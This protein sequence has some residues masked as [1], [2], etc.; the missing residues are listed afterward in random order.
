MD[1]GMLS[2]TRLDV[3]NYEQHFLFMRKLE[4]YSASFWTVS[5]L[6]CPVPMEIGVGYPHPSFQGRLVQA[7]MTK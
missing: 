4:V 6:V 5:Q 1:A 3:L 2:L 7:S